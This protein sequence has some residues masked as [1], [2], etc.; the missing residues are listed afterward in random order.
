MK[1][2]K[3]GAALFAMVVF[4]A[5]E[6]PVKGAGDQEFKGEIADSQCALNVHSLSRSHKEM[7]KT[8]IMGKTDADCTRYCVHERGG[9]YV[10]QS[11][12][13]VYRLDNQELSA[14]FAGRKVSV[15]GALDESSNTIRVRVI[16]PLDEVKVDV[17]AKQ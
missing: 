16:Q 12:T 10:L 3:R 7:L 4:A 15:T 1:G 13:H 14:G 17:P 5:V 2:F 9:Q 11:K 6:Q 8:G